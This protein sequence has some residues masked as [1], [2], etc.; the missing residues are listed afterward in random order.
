MNQHPQAGTFTIGGKT[1][2]VMQIN[3]VHTSIVPK[4]PPS[5]VWSAW[6]VTGIMFG[7]VASLSMIAWTALTVLGFGAALYY[8]SLSRYAVVFDMSSG[9]VTAFESD[10]KSKV[11]EMRDAIVAGIETGYFPNYLQ[12]KQGA[13]GS[14]RQIL[15]S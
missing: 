5:I 11:E 9:S 13:K 8:L 10:D 2:N 4:H 15:D 6:F 1:F 7:F 3:S 14:S 12:S